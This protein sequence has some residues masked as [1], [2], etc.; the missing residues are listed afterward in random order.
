VCLG[1]GSFILCGLTAIPAL[2]LG[3]KA[4]K[5]IDASPGKFSNG[6][7]ALVGIISGGGGC[8]FFALFVIGAIANLAKPK[9]HAQATPV[10]DSSSVPITSM[11]ANPTTSANP[12]AFASAERATSASAVPIVAMEDAAPP[13]DPI[14]EA[15]AKAEEEKAKKLEEKKRLA[16]R[17]FV[18]ASPDGIGTALGS[19]NDPD[20]LWATTYNDNFVR[21]NGKFESKGMF[22]VKFI[23]STGDYTSFSCKDFDPAHDATKFDIDTM[24]TYASIA[25]E[26]RLTGYGKQLGKSKLEFELSDCI[27]KTR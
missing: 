23:A 13:S 6:W 1:L 4:K 19:K 7:M 20:E 9:T 21:W 15:K 17:K 8:I 2:V 27:A 18:A 22:L 16:T 3:L 26:G 11:S 24:K 12:V 5:E 25:V 10:A 14:A